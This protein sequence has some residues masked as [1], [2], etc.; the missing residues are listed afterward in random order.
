MV[1]I[2]ALFALSV[3]CLAAVPPPNTPE[4]QT[5][6]TTTGVDAV[7]IVTETDALGWRL[8]SEVLDS[9][10]EWGIPL[11][12]MLDGVMGIMIWNEEI[13]EFRIRGSRKW[14]L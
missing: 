4:I 14:E 2:I 13:G 1:V 11:S 6:T 7:G 8:S 5:I 12:W 9:N 3:P 10:L